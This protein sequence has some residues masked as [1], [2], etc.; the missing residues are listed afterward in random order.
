MI[1]Q[2]ARTSADR[3]ILRWL[4]GVAIF[5]IGFTYLGSA[6]LPFVL[7]LALGYLLNPLVLFLE[8]WGF[9]RLG[10]TI[11]I[12][13]VFVLIFSTGA[14]IAVPILVDQ[15]GSL[16]TNFPRYV[17][18]LQSFVVS[19]N[20]EFLKLSRSLSP[21]IGMESS[22]TS[23][24]ELL[25]SASGEGASW[26]TSFLKSLASGGASLVDALSILVLAPVVAY[27]VLVDWD[28]I[29]KALQSFSPPGGRR[30][31]QEILHEIDRAMAGFLRGQL[32][33]C[34]FLGAWYSIGLSLAGLN[35]GFLIGVTAGILSFVPYVGTLAAFVPSIIIA[36]TQGWPDWRL[37]LT[38]V[39]VVATG[40]FLEGNILAPRLVGASVG[41]HP[42]WLMLALVIFGTLFGFSGLLISVPVASIIGVLARHSVNRFSR[43][44]E[45]D[46]IGAP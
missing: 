41:L 14:I 40:L 44:S 33:V 38:V 46:P 3:L 9:D 26:V 24:L 8:R 34:V 43:D 22:A 39:G 18:R 25:K 21:K 32:L 45:G 19:L 29:A 5:C 27:Y 7:G 23:P 15:A 36:F 37:P 16:G 12:L 28:R 6:L 17:A 2:R 30:E 42:V 4:V 10:A 31:T 20:E 35:F 1:E 11:F 13:V